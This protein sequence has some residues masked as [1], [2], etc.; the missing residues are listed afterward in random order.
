[1]TRNER[2]KRKSEFLRANGANP[3]LV[4]RARDWSW[5]RIHKL[6]EAAKYRPINQIGRR[7]D[8]C[9]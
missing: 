6:V 8:R 9:V 5:E 2:R 1:M 7:F 3:P 4:Y